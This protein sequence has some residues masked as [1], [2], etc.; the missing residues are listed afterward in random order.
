[1]KRGYAMR[2]RNLRKLSLL[3]AMLFLLA[4]CGK[5]EDADVPTEQDESEIQIGVSFDSF[6]IE[7]WL[8]DRDV[9]VATAKEAGAQVNVQNANGDVEEQISHIEYFIKQKM[10]VIVIVATDCNR[11]SDIIREAKSQGI[12]VI[13]YD[14]LIND[15]DVDLYISFDNRRVG[16]LMAEGLLEGEALHKVIMICGSPTDANVAE[17]EEGFRRIMEEAQVDIIDTTYADGWRAELA[18]EYVYENIDKI[19]KVDGIMCGNDNLATMAVHALAE[20]QL[21]GKIQVVGQDGDL[22]ACQRIVEGTQKMTVYKPVQKEAMVAANYAIC[23]AKGDLLEELEHMQNG[24]YSIPYVLLEPI[25]VDSSN[26]DDIII[27]GGVH[28]ADDVYLN[29]PQ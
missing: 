3:I 12:K 2:I 15:A 11:L 26:I 7:R 9:F 14:R 25:S 20:K 16:E 1:M 4:G 13:A 29:V 23:L 24:A 6:V 8:T 18:G 10:D 5:S 28:L 27:G 19:M 17:V 22:E 21:A